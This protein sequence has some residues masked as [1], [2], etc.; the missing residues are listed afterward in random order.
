MKKKHKSKQ[1]WLN[2]HFNDVYVKMA[3]NEG[4]RSR[5]VYKLQE[6]HERDKLFRSGM[7][8]VDLGAAPGGWSQIAAKYVGDKGRVFALDILP[9]EPLDGV[10]FLQGDFQEQNVLDNMLKLMNGRNANLVISDM[11]P[12][13]SGMSV[14]DQP[15][16]MYLSELA[17]DFAGRVLASG[18]DMVIKVFQ[19]AG[20]D[21]LVQGLRQSFDKVTIRKP[22]ASRPRSREVYVVAKN[23]HS[24]QNH[25]VT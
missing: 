2:E 8:V 4:Y 23:Y 24:Y 25:I 9:M 20:F 5:A 6:I 17:V 1:P 15:K 22:K 14:I 7:V 21:N 12:N 11:A 19:G 3:Q 13:I 18:G 10:E 16:G